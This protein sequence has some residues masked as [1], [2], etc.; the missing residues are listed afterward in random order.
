M[1][2]SKLRMFGNQ[3]ERRAFEV[4]NSVVHCSLCGDQCGLSS[5]WLCFSP[6]ADSHESHGP[7][8]VAFQNEVCSGPKHSRQPAEQVSKAHKHG[9]HPI[10]SAE[11]DEGA[12]RTNCG[13]P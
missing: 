8:P 5:T 11:N 7:Q 10:R 6:C 12:S 3:I 1:L 13:R 4:T 9:S 2:E